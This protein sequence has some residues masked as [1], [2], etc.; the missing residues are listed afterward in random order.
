MTEGDEET[1]PSSPPDDGIV[2]PAAMM[3]A[4][5]G[6]G[7]RRRGVSNV[8]SVATVG[9]F[10]LAVLYTLYIARVLILPIVLAVFLSFI[11]WPLV[12]GL[13]RL[14]VPEALG[15]LLVL[16]TLTASFGYGIYAL[17]GPAASWLESAPQALYRIELRL[18]TVKQTVEDVE[19]ATNR[20]EE[21]ASGSDDPKRQEVT[22]R[23]PSLVSLMWTNA[24]G[25]IASC[26]I[27]LVLAFFLLASGDL[28]LNKCLRVLPTRRDRYMLLAMAREL[29]D[30]ISGYLLTVTL[31]NAALGVAV[32][33]AMALCGLPN[34]VLWGVMAATF[35][36]VPYIGSAVGITCVAA[37]SLIT[38]DTLSQAITPPAVYLMLTTLEAYLL[39]PAVLSRRFTLNPLVVLVSLLFWG[40]IWGV[41]GALLAMPIIVT[42][43]IVCDYVPSLATI[44]EFLSN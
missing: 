37:A 41:P 2:A 12:R 17:S 34:A 27:I 21:I 42:L 15:A 10:A 9:L 3:A 24:G 6:T 4:A 40:W 14:Y 38:F 44:G 8:V 20:V 18:R 22:L 25:I 31:I 36:F 1:A 16:T 11:L 35:N 32:G 5:V 26:F 7:D 30:T 39:T 23:G 43:R 13:R 29:Q 33:V 28:F 19:A